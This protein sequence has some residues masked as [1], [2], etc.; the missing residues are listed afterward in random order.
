L[1][2][3][4]AG[5]RS[6]EPPATRPDYYTFMEVSRTASK[7]EITKSYKKLA[8]KLHPD[9]TGNAD[10]EDFKFL[11]EAYSVLSDNL[12]RRDYDATHFSARA[13]AAPPTYAAS[14]AA[15]RPW[16]APPAPAPPP[17]LPGAFPPD[18]GPISIDSKSS[19]G[20]CF[21][22]TPWSVSRDGTSQEFCSCGSFFEC[23]GPK[24]QVNKTLVTE[25]GCMEPQPGGDFTGYHSECRT[26]ACLPPPHHWQ[27][28]EYVDS[29]ELRLCRLSP[30]ECNRIDF[31]QQVPGSVRINGR[32]RCPEGQ[33][34]VFRN[35]G[36]K[37]RGCGQRALSMISKT[38]SEDRCACVQ[39][40]AETHRCCKLDGKSTTK[41]AWL[42]LE[43][44]NTN[45]RDKLVC[46]TV[47]GVKWRH[48]EDDDFC[49]SQVGM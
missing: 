10:D 16:T 40:Y 17:C 14:A 44:L 12:K 49:D 20:G 3:L 26:C 1:L 39:D 7:E 29:Y 15:S 35:I 33:V 23:T 31:L 36:T 45:W 19:F 6:E 13:S 47:D 21:G 4:A 9:K 18:C 5:F 2:S 34:C 48:A 30:A 24:H 37:R 41:Y 8:L 27:R 46:P 32:F 25:P 28:R 11:Q 42:T 38:C 22:G 43:E